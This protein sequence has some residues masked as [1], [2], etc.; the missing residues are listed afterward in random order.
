M[1]VLKRNT[2]VLCFVA[3]LMVA[4]A[5]TLLLSPCDAHKEGDETA[6]FPLPAS[7]YSISFPTYTDDKCKKFC[8]GEGKPPAPMAFCND[9]NNCCCPVIQ[10]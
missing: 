4:M 3:T 6:A 10:L 2:S 5:T 7:C 1:A 8:G 9:N